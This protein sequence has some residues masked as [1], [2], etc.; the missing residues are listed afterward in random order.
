MTTTVKA[1]KCCLCG[2]ECEDIYG[3]NPYPLAQKGVCCNECNQHVIMARMVT[4]EGVKNRFGVDDR[5]AKIIM[6][7]ILDHRRLLC[8][9]RDYSL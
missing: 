1:P 7:S 2:R 9:R 3:N 6:K 5:G 4:L 8:K